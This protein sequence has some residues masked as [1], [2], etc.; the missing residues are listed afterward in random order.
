MSFV[1]LHGHTGHSH[2][3]AIIDVNELF[4][5]AKEL[6][7]PAVAITDHGVMAGAW[8]AYKAYK[9]TG[10]KYIPGNEIYFT[11]DL[12]VK[13]SK[14][15]HLILLASNE[16]GYR[17]LL[18]LTAESFKKPVN[19][20]G[21]V[22]PRISAEML[23]KWNEGLYCTSA[24]MSSLI[25]DGVFRDD[26]EKAES[27][28][29]LLKDIFG[30]RFFL[31]LQPHS[32]RFIKKDKEKGKVYKFN[33]LVLNEELIKIANKLDIQMVPT[34]DSHY[35]T[36]EHEKYHDMIQAI[37]SKKP[38]DSLN[39]KRYAYR[40]P[41]PTCEGFGVFPKDSKTKCGDCDGSGTD[42]PQPCSE[43]YLKSDEDIR[44]FFTEHYSAEFADEIIGNT[45]RIAESCEPPDYMEPSG[46]RLPVFGMDHIRD[47][48]DCDSFIAWRDKKQSRKDM[49]DDVA[50]LKFKCSTAFKS[51]CAGMPKAKKHKYWDRLLK[52]IDI[53]ESRGFCSYMLIVGDYLGWARKGGLYVGPG[54]GCLTG[55]TKV[56]TSDSGFKE[57]KAIEVGDHVFS[58][59]G[60]SKKV[61]NTFEYDVTG[62]EL[63][64]IKTENSF[65]PIV[66]TKDHKVFGSK[67]KET[68]QY[69][70][71]ASKG[72]LSKFKV[73]RWKDIGAPSF[74]PAED[75][76]VNDMM[77]M[78]W[79]QRRVVN[80]SPFDLAKYA[81]IKG[82]VVGDKTISC[83]CYDGNGDERV[84]NTIKI[85]RFIKLDHDFAYLLGR[86][87][88]DGW[89]SKNK[90][91]WGVAFNSNDQAGI[92]RVSKIVE[93]MGFKYTV[94]KHRDKNIC[95][96]MVYNKILWSFF[97]DIFP[98]YNFSSA[99]K[100]IGI[101]KYLRDN[102]LK[103]LLHGLIDSDGHVSY[104]KRHL[105]RECIDTTSYRLTL[106]IKEALLYL[107]IPS[108]VN[109]RESYVNGANTCSKGYE[110]K[111]KGIK[112]PKSK[113]LIENDQGYFTKIIGIEKCYEGK[114]YDIT[115][116]DDHSY[117]TSN[118]AVHN[119]GASSL[120]GFF[121]DIHECD[122]IQY[123]LIFERFVNKYKK[124]LPDVD[125]DVAPS[126][127]GKIY[128]Y[129][130]KKYGE[131]YVCYIS[132]ISR[133]TPKVAIKDVSRS[134]KIG[135]DKSTAFGLANKITAKIPDQVT[136]PNGKT[137]EVKTIQMAKEHCAPLRKFFER[138]PEVEDFS[139]HITGL[140][141]NFSTH[142]GGILISDVPLPEYAPLRRDKDDAVAIQYDKY[143]TEEVGLVKMDLLRIET[144][145]IMKEAYREAHKIGIKIPPYNKIPY[146][147]ASAFKMIQ[148]GK[149]LGLF[150]LEGGTLASLC[151]PMKPNN[152]ED[153]AL[154]NALGR[155]S[156]SE[157]ERA[158]F[159]SRR[160][161]RSKVTYPNKLLEPALK[162]TYGVSIFDEQLQL[163]AKH[164]ANW[165]LAKADSLRKLTKLKAKGAKL[166]EQLEKDF[167][168]DTVSH[169]GI[170]KKEA[171]YIWDHVVI[172]FSGYGFCKSHAIAYSILGYRTAYYKAKATAPF[173]CA[174]LNAK[175]KS[176]ARNRDE[177]IDA[178]K[179][180]MRFFGIDIAPCDINQSA[181]Y[182]S[183][184]NNK[185]IVT[186]F[187]AVK[188]LGEK[189]LANIVT[190]QPYASLPDFLSRV[191]SSSVNKTAIQALA[192]AGAFDSFGISR[193]FVHD[194]FAKIR[195]EVN[196]YVKKLDD[197]HF[198]CEDRTKP[199]SDYLDNFVSSVDG[200]AQVEWTI[201]EKMT[202]EKDVLG[203]YISG[204][205][206]QLYPGFF[207]GG[208]WNFTG[209]KLQLTPDRSLVQ[210][211]GIITEIT[212]LKYK[213]G[214]KV[215]AVFGKGTIEN[216]NGDRMSLTIW[217]ETYVKMQKYFDKQMPLPIR[218]L[219]SVNEYRGEKGLVLNKVKGLYTG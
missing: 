57:L 106:D 51:Y 79:P 146:G 186:G 19:I 48:D 24:C 184:V 71:L 25:A 216:V 210:A 35:L 18:R 46:H 164:V 192:K 178:V 28:A 114:V 91:Q 127:H 85:K 105:V 199:F 99:T 96:L 111:F 80:F 82:N 73:K 66:L 89:V 49:A 157:D 45:A 190:H 129:I 77:F 137:V 140:P 74:I 3:D 213:T 122:P 2:L 168:E 14:R 135:G 97:K 125:S 1:N 22:V 7:Q 203:A 29:K 13:K 167:V 149:V 56:L 179:R 102:L 161:G 130:E 78:P 188:G 47:C 206:D 155:P 218:G 92:A 118:Y 159:I 191:P 113:S 58:H 181:E 132:N 162:D 126:D 142:A 83:I 108:G 134:I 61:L 173:L 217:H 115:V 5:R 110:I 86:W 37:A 131:E 42:L 33:Q 212:E 136:L 193:K 75:M 107:K 76:S 150:Q 95:Q 67:R 171:Q 196:A 98:D 209:K 202:H 185:K 148:S 109:T 169:S 16:T 4:Q 198:E 215:G 52:E 163:L 160:F 72:S 112:T 123:G 84:K 175:T 174:N 119:S 44:S 69:R 138:F 139:E 34:C 172:P 165:D 43:Y 17:N 187:G 12:N 87:I 182:Y 197:S 38:L 81:S 207:K 88:G 183:C 9:E 156:C 176:N 101:F 63:L 194:H 93:S 200:Y 147:D 11:E 195:T 201:Q 166:A 152:I 32:L 64:K 15:G 100:Y 21:R 204:S 40:D 128:D 151:K 20:M 180:E 205:I 144:L 31:E 94:I 70:R 8:E 65:D 177:K 6:G 143:H 153:I 50:Y 30:D 54:R 10:V 68:D 90:A 62:E 124:D 53:L 39:R 55:S 219:F 145:D 189:A 170:T 103:D 214:K 211:E 27:L 41:C 154:I 116:E 158:E 60:K 133:I 23:S 59:T 117:V 36:P 104:G 120:V 121:L 26:L 141:R 208:A